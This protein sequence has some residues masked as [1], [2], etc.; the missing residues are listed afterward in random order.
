MTQHGR[1]QSVGGTVQELTQFP[2]SRGPITLPCVS[3]VQAFAIRGEGSETLEIDVYDVIGDSWF[4]DAVTAKSVRASLKGAKNAKQITLR[5]NSAGGDVFD[6]FAIYNLLNEH[7]AHVVAHV[8]ALA[9]SMAS[10]IVMAADEIHIAP[11]AMLMIHNPWTMAM[12]DAEDLR[13]GAELL[14]KLRGQIADAYVARTGLERDEVLALMDA[15]TWMTA[16]EAKERGFVDVVKSAK[17]KSRDD[18]KALAAFDLS[19]FYQTPAVF[20][21]AVTRAIARM[22]RARAE[23]IKAMSDEEMTELRTLLGLEPEATGA[24]I[25]DAVKA[26]KGDKEEPAEEQPPPDGEANALRAQLATRDAAYREALEQRDT[27]RAQLARFEDEEIKALVDGAIA[28]EPG[29]GPKRGALEKLARSDR[30]TFEEL[31]G[32]ASP[33]GPILGQV[34]KSDARRGRSS[35]GMS[36]REALFFRTLKNARVKNAAGTLAN[37]D[38]LRVMARE[39]AAEGQ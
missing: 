32:S 34:A 16:A 8:D 7:P 14:D 30:G 2:G 9:A 39:R 6:G 21:K 38:E 3:S 11:N 13:A 27:A 15:E 33:A 10:V 37:D 26:L 31:H 24:E 20:A 35:A 18:A 12:G 4:G 22:D 36:D 25:L 1:A 23:E 28:R 29:L 17:K 5:V 19:G